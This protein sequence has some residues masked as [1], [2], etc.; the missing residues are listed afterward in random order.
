M[1]ELQK[2]NL[3]FPYFLQKSDH[4][5]AYKSDFSLESMVKED[6]RGESIEGTMRVQMLKQ[7]NI[8]NVYTIETNYSVNNGPRLFKQVDYKFLE[9]IAASIADA[10]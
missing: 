8:T 4:F 3:K 2:H 5:S 1:L 10:I 9:Q 6:N 7:L